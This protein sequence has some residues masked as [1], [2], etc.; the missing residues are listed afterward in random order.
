[1]KFLKHSSAWVKEWSDTPNW[2]FLVASI[3]IVGIL[4]GTGFIGVEI[5]K[6]QVI[7]Y[8]QEYL[9]SLTYDLWNHD[10]TPKVL[11]WQ[12]PKR[13]WEDYS[14]T[15]GVLIWQ[16]SP[17]CAE[18]LIVGLTGSDTNQVFEPIVLIDSEDPHKRKL[19]GI[20]TYGHVPETRRAPDL[21]RIVNEA[22]REQNVK[23]YVNGEILKYT[24]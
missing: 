16:Y 3:L 10:P 1:M 23:W 19:W 12:W 4:L 17:I 22:V 9:D 18:T 7:K 2:A 24:P 6:A 8:N 5:G 15:Y 11:L 20:S 14:R 13:E 21:R